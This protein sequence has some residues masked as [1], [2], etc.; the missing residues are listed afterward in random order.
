[1]MRAY[2]LRALLKS[3][4]FTVIAIVALALGVGANTAIVGVGYALRLKPLPYRDPARLA[5]VW[6]HNVPRDRKNNVVS[7]G[8]YLHWRDM[9]TSFAGMSVVSMTFRTAMT[10]E[11]E[12]EELPF[13]VVNASLFPMPGVNVAL[14]RGLSAADDSSTRRRCAHQRSSLAPPV[15]R[16]S[17][18]V[19]RTVRFGGNPRTVVGVMPP[20]FR[21]S[22]PTSTC[23]FRYVFGRRARAA[24]AVG[25]G[26][27]AAEGRRDLRAGAG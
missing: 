2:A 18:I 16:R 21:F 7:P 10:G 8:N 14:G 9:N 13:Q 3:P 6:E 4:G 27:R 11:G 25:D 23:G 15:R 19:N 22:T 20:G 17:R 5:V 24:G 12:P 1:M 26:R